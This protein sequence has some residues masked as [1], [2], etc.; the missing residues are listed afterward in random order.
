M[1]FKKLLDAGIPV[2]ASNLEFSSLVAND[3]LQVPTNK[4]WREA[5]K[6]SQR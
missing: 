2:R 5:R 3:L 6:F 1:Q 4:E